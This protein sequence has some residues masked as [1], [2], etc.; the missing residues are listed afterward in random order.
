MVVAFRSDDGNEGEGMVGHV[1][2][3]R[4]FGQDWA[5]QVRAHETRERVAALQARAASALAEIVQVEPHLG[6]LG[7]MAKEVD[8]ARQAIRVQ[9]VA[10]DRECT[11]A[12][13]SARG[14]LAFHGW[15]GEQAVLRL[16]GP[17]FWTRD[18]PIF[19]RINRLQRDIAIVRSKASDTKT[20]AAALGV[21]LGK[22]G[23][24]RA[25]FSEL[26]NSL[27]EDVR[28]LSQGHFAHIV[29]ML[30]GRSGD[31][32]IEISGSRLSTLAPSLYGNIPTWTFVTDF[33]TCRS[34][35]KEIGRIQ[36]G[37][38]MATDKPS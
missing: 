14:R 16:K 4:F 32:P 21:L 25:R 17:S 15:D 10:L 19:Q 7:S 31:H 26:A 30:G 28:A 37:M 34:I 1:C 8:N 6:P 29:E 13:R 38:S 11:N 36:E 35:G 27:R 18:P 3:R 12:V 24:A 33:D 5:E 22:L 20:S 23:S 9:L 2:G